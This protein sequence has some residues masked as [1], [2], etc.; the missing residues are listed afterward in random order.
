M[1]FAYLRITGEDM[2]P[3]DITLR[4]RLEPDTVQKK[5]QEIAA[6]HGWLGEG[7][8]QSDCWQFSI[9]SEESESV[10]ALTDRFLDLLLPRA[11]HLREL[12]EQFAAE[13]YISVYPESRQES[14][15]FGVQTSRKLADIGLPL[16]FCTTYLG[17]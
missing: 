14:I 3:E 13:L 12:A 17:E 8:Y 2:E 6:R 10:A 16:Y 11:E 9:E 1:T 15:L 7:E 4:L 5:G